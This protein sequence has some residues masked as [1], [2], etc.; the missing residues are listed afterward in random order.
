MIGASPRE[1]YYE[2]CAL[3]LRFTARMCQRLASQGRYDI[4]KVD[5]CASS[6]VCHCE[7]NSPRF[8]VE[9]CD[10][11]RDRLLD[12]IYDCILRK[13]FLNNLFRPRDLKWRI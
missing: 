8:P 13:R 11:L 2:K 5:I 6:F 10:L 12:Y 4:I 9:L 1:L 3:N 7:L